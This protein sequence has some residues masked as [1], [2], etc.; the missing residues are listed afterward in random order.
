LAT[1]DALITDFKTLSIVRVPAKV[2]IFLKKVGSD[3]SSSPYFTDRF[4]LKAVVRIFP[5]FPIGKTAHSFW[6]PAVALLRDPKSYFS[7]FIPLF[8]N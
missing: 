7:Q 4:V 6:E 5:S 3:S 1:I 2:A 8:V